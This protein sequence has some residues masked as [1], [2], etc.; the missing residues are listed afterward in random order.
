MKRPAALKDA[1]RRLWSEDRDERLSA[2]QTLNHLIL[3][4]VDVRTAQPRLAMCL[5]DPD[6]DVRLAA[7]HICEHRA[8]AGYDVGLVVPELLRSQHDPDTEIR[9]S[10]R[11]ALIHAD[12][13]LDGLLAGHFAPPDPET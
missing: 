2:L 5:R 4:M 8:E 6:H 3:D 1:I 13:R 9:R 11:R 7:V 12:R 10:A